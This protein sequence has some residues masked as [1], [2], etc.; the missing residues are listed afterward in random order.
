[1]GNKPKW[2]EALSNAMRGQLGTT[3]EV[4]TNSN[5]S[6]VVLEYFGDRWHKDNTE[7]SPD[8][9]FEDEQEPEDEEESEEDEGGG[10]GSNPSNQKKPPL[11]TACDPFK[12]TPQKKVQK[13]RISEEFKDLDWDEPGHPQGLFN[14]KTNA[15]NEKIKNV[16]EEMKAQIDQQLDHYYKTGKF[17]INP[18]TMMNKVFSD[19]MSKYGY[20]SIFNQWFKTVAEKHTWVKHA[21]EKYQAITPK[22]LMKKVTGKLTMDKI[23][24]LLKLNP[25][26]MGHL[27]KFYDIVKILKTIRTNPIKFVLN[28]FGKTGGMGDVMSSLVTAFGDTGASD[29]LSYV[30]TLLIT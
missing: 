23:G 16:Y 2:N 10:G 4:F 30:I 25:T 11:N 27:N 9:D 19:I 17:T 8:V 15:K 22:Q 3:R 13:V 1:M 7:G 12:Q 18:T 24:K 26:L 28:A 21:W 5:G 20:K 14:G 29:V 6:N